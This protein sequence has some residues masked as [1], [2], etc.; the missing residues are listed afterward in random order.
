MAQAEKILPA[1]LWKLF[2]QEARESCANDAGAYFQFS[3][4]E[5]ACRVWIE[6]PKVDT[7]ERWGLENV[8]EKGCICYGCFARYGNV[9]DSLDLVDAEKNQIRY[10]PAIEVRPFHSLHPL[11]LPHSLQCT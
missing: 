11:H 4:G 5:K 7:K 3:D 6:D 9:L 8:N 1:F 2:I 10:R